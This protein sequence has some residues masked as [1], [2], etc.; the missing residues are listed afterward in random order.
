[1]NKK[2]STSSIIA[3]SVVCL[4]LLVAIFA[5]LIA[6]FSVDELDSSIAFLP[7]SFTHLLGTDYLGRD[8]FSRLVFGAR[9]S[10]FSTFLILFIILA[11]GLI[12][13]ALSGFIGGKLDLVLM[14]V[15]DMFLSMPTIVLAL[16]F[17]GVLGAGLTNVI[18]AIALTHWA[19]YARIVRSIVLNFKSKEFVL[20]AKTQGL[21]TFDTL[22]FYLF[23]PII[24]QC[25]V[26]ISMDIGHIMLHIAGLSFLGLG[27]QAPMA[28]WGVM[29]ADCK[30]YLWSNPLLLL[31]PG[32]ALAILSFSCN[33]LG[34]GLR[35]YFDIEEIKC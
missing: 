31:Y 14:R 1:M 32:L 5:P 35:D 9:I 3:L 15:C 29:I 33:V 30:D 34:E 26:L 11:L 23:V 27:V 28:E 19:W 8:V 17:I 6:P 2:L 18:I 13:G 12:I 21:S 10:L 20:L 7:P 4:F 24:T 25:I 16:F 22:R